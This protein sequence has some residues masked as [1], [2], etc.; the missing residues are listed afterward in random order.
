MLR[1]PRRAK[2][3]APTTLRKSPRRPRRYRPLGERLEPRR[4]LAAD[5]PDADVE[6]LDD[7]PGFYRL[8]RSLAAPE[9]EG[10]GSGGG[11]GGGGSG[12]GEFGT[13][14]G[15]ASPPTVTVGTMGDRYEGEGSG[16]GNGPL[17]AGSATHAESVEIWLAGGGAQQMLGYAWVSGD[18]WEYL[19][20][21]VL[22]DDPS[23]TPSDAMTIK[24]VAKGSAEFADAVATAEFTVTNLNPRVT[25]LGPTHLYEGDS[26]TYTFGVD[27]LSHDTFTDFAIDWADAQESSPDPSGAAGYSEAH[28]YRDEGEYF[29][30]AAVTD[31]DTGVGYDIRKVTVVNVAPS[32]HAGPDLTVNEGSVVSLQGS[33]T[34]P[35]LDDAHN[36]TWQVASNNGQPTA[37]GNE[38]NFT[39]NALDDGVYTATFTADDRDGGVAS[40]T[41]T[42][43]V[44]NVDPQNV[45][46]HSDVQR[47]EGTTVTLSATFTDPGPLDTH[48]YR[49]SIPGLAPFTTTSSSIDF[50]VTDEGPYLIT[51]TVIDDD[52]GTGAD[53]A[54]V[55]G[56]NLPPSL[57]LESVEFEIDEGGRVLL[58]GAFHDPGIF[59]SLHAVIDWGDGSP[60]ESH[61]GYDGSTFF[62]YHTYTDDGPWVNGENQPGTPSDT[63]TVQIHLTDGDGDY[64]DPTATVTVNNVDPVVALDAS[65]ATPEGSAAEL[66][67]TIADVGVADLQ[68]VVVAW[69]DGTS[70]THSLAAGAFSLSHIYADDDPS[71]SSS[72]DYAITVTATDD[73][74]GSGSASTALTVEN[75]A[76]HGERGGHSRHHP[77]RRHLLD[78]R[79]GPRRSDPRRADGDRGHRPELRR[80]HRRRGR[81]A[82][83]RGR[84]QRRR[85]PRVPTPRLHRPRRRRHLRRIRRPGLGQRNRS[86]RIPHSS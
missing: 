44:L 3:P 47:N 63:Y 10:S 36:L 71:G 69:G 21:Y 80:R 60:P 86:R 9:G 70:S 32:V 50:T 25:M 40:D 27:D 59:D 81:N 73:D 41:V 18:A 30:T 66:T 37:Y 17:A 58:E 14:S 56:N 24:A 76:P 45:T 11:S 64:A 68:T 75:V 39:F 22:D 4:L 26:A 48:T 67:G 29:A 12:P 84:T 35:G 54:T 46:V 19:G 31:D 72:D 43:T 85:R 51:C 38:Q 34:D 8:D 77:G 6:A 83:R 57:A 13:G 78:P 15:C 5:L 1:W 52:A 62:A 28:V 16:A 20:S 49:W 65:P 42:I 7:L 74:Q 55:G 33:F 2:R 82:I 79:P 53:T 61:S 23:D